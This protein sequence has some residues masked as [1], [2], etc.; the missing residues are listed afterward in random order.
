MKVK[1]MHEQESIIND[2][3]TS[4]D[5]TYLLNIIGNIIY[6]TNDINLLSNL[7]NKLSKYFYKHAMYYFNNN[8]SYDG[9]KDESNSKLNS[10]AD[11]FIYLLIINNVQLYKN[12]IIK[13][14]LLNNFIINELKI[15]L[16]EFT[17][18][19]SYDNN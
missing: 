7:Y 12:K 18:S 16:I 13:N 3:E 15:I 9:Y 17:K 19:L 1:V 6:Y 8:Q 11:T 2:I 14:Y 10:F 4:N 5:I